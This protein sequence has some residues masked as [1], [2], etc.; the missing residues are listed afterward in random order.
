MWIPAAISLAVII[1]SIIVLII[2]QN[3]ENTIPKT[4]TYRTI[5]IIGCIIPI[6]VICGNYAYM[7]TDTLDGT[8]IAISGIYVCLIL[9]L[10]YLNKWKTNK[11]NY[12]IFPILLLSWVWII[13]NITPYMLSTLYEHLVSLVG[14]TTGAS[15]VKNKYKVRLIISSI[16]CFVLLFTPMDC[17]SISDIKNKV[18]NISIEYVKDLG[19]DITSDDKVIV[20]NESTR[21]KPI[22]LMIVRLNSEHKLKIERHLKLIYLRGNI[23]EFQE[24]L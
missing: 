24:I 20:L 15:I 17:L 9:W 1:I 22:K 11:Y 10:L 13:K 23:I 8:I 5:E 6:F 16:I 7:M 21:N 18:D 3:G 2:L 14:A 4:K 12:I 19:Y